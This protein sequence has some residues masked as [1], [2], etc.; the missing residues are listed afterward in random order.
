MATGGRAH[1]ARALLFFVAALAAPAFALPCES[2]LEERRRRSLAALETELRAA[3]AH[4]SALERDLRL[5]RLLYYQALYRGDG[6]DTRA[7]L[8]RALAT[9]ERVREAAP[10]EPGALLGYAAAKGELARR[11]P[12]F[13]ALRYARDVHTALQ[14][15]KAVA[16]AYEGHAA[17]RGLAILHQEAPGILSFGSSRKASQAIEA[18][19]AGAPTHPGNLV[20]QAQLLERQGEREKAKAVARRALEGAGD[21][22]FSVES[23]LWTRQSCEILRS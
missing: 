12:L 20:A 13:T 2:L 15:L 17:E 22:A 4:A 14:R 5:S 21:E 3:E 11:A 23:W 18:A 6:A 19:L 1:R 16:P 8:E 9:I 7:L 10:D